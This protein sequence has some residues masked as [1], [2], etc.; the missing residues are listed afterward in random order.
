MDTVKAV[1]ITAA[2]HQGAF[3]KDVIDY[4]ATW[5]AGRF[6]YP[7]L[8]RAEEGAIAPL[9]KSF[10]EEHANAFERECVPGHV[11]GSALVVS[12]DLSHVL[13]TL[14]GKL[15]LWL[16]LGGHADGEPLPH[17]VAMREAEEESGLKVLS[18]LAYE[19]DLVPKRSDTRPLPFD[20]DRHVIPARKTEP[21]HFHYDAR[22]LLIGHPD[23]ALGISDESQ[24]LRWFTI[25]EARKVT[26][27]RSMHRQFDKLEWLRHAVFLMK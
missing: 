12:P 23:H 3:I 17:A 18:H 14:H 13:L 2:M 20:L 6:A 1:A 7:G 8:D 15:N 24:D 16:Q 9:F 22:Y 27:E 26:T 10:L 4:G 19:T 21:E 11:T 5:G 25:P